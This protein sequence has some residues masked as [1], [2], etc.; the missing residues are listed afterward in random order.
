MHAS[1]T[2]K[3]DPVFLRIALLLVRWDDRKKQISFETRQQFPFHRFPVDYFY[4]QVL[5]NSLFFKSNNLPA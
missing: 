1:A 4:L 3:H 5:H 2:T